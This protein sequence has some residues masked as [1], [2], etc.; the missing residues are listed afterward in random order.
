MS[1]SNNSFIKKQK[2]L[3]RKKKREEK[4][5]KKIERKKNAMGG[6]LESMMAYVDEFG[7]IT[8]TPPEKGK[9]NS[10]IFLVTI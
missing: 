1:K 6:D 5:E 8:S 10:I 3:V 9:Q 7:N 4:E 2:E